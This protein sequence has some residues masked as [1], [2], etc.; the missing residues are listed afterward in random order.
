MA[1]RQPA[2]DPIH[3]PAV[4]YRA[5]MVRRCENGCWHRLSTPTAQTIVGEELIRLSRRVSRIPRRQD[6]STVVVYVILIAIT[7]ALLVLTI[8]LACTSPPYRPSGD[9]G[10]DEQHHMWQE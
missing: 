8:W 6:I 4:V 9:V 1:K 2:F 7:A 3:P 5:Y 10:P